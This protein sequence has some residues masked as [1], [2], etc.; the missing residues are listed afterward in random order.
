MR[1]NIKIIIFLRT[2]SRRSALNQSPSYNLNTNHSTLWTEQTCSVADRHCCGNDLSKTSQVHIVLDTGSPS[3][4]LTDA[5]QNQLSLRVGGE[6]AMF[7][8]TLSSTVQLRDVIA[9]A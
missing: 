1:P 3:T 4:Y 8:V 2:E 7:V 9:S 5:V 6:R